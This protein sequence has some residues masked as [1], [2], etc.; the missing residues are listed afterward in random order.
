M[1]TVRLFDNGGETLDRYTAIF[2]YNNECYHFSH[3]P[4]S[5]VGVALIDCNYNPNFNESKD[6]E[7]YGKPIEVKDLPQEAQEYIDKKIKLAQL[8]NV[9]D[10]LCQNK[11]FVDP[12]DYLCEH[13]IEIDYD[14]GEITI[15]DESG[16]K[17]TLIIKGS[18]KNSGKEL[19]TVWVGGTEVV[20]HYV[21]KERATFI[22]Q[23]YINDGYDDVKIEEVELPD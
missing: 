18:N 16:E 7:M 11:E 9:Y 6:I 4:L 8:E 19:Y 22:A 5:P 10:V 15:T 2:D 1:K 23:D 3:N 14:K 12:S 17:F 20:D 13:N 21:T